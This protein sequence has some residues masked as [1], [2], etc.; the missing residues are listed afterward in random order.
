MKFSVVAKKTDGT[1][2][3]RVI[4]AES[5]FAV[6]SQVEKDGE[7][8]VSLKE[9]V[10][11]MPAWMS[12]TIGGVNNETKITFTKNLSAMLLAGLTLSRSLSVLE[13]QS[14][15]PVMKKIV[16]DLE[17]KIKAGTSFHEALEEHKKVFSKLFIAM[18]KAGEE[19]GTLADTLKVVAVQMERSEALTKKIKGAMIYPCIILFAVAVIGILM[20]IFVVPVLAATFEQLGAALPVATQI[21]LN[22]SNFVTHN[23]VVVIVGLIILVVGGMIFLRSKAGGT[24]VLFI[25][26]HLPVI[27]ELVKETFSARAARTLSS[28]L[29]SGVEMLNALSIT[30][31]VVGE[32]V[33][34]KVVAESAVRVRKGEQL[35]AAFNDYPKLYPILFTDMITVGEETG[36]VAD[37]LT[38]VAIYYENDV[39]DR[40]KDLSTIIEPVLMLVIGLFV[41]IFAVAMIAPIYQLS[42]AI[43]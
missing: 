28:L 40:T 36:K 25:A 30:E 33:F 9:G 5:R 10:G 17:G 13:R 31:E 20:L 3:T 32:N 22:L 37:M 21:I 15:N 18:T 7:S 4:E 1:Q 39:E 41:G 19:G 24:T 26:L 12:I 2:E 23:L 6:Y 14:A 34:G 38:Q 11:G 16:I 27:G 43:S 29:T 35:S 42:S 8:V